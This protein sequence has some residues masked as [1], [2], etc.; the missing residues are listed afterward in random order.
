MVGY[1]WC[2]GGMNHVPCHPGL[3]VPRKGQ[4]NFRWFSALSRPA[5]YR[6]ARTVHLEI[7]LGMSMHWVHDV[8]SMEPTK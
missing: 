1:P 5:S 2:T 8:G 4:A 6:Y 7:L 3:R